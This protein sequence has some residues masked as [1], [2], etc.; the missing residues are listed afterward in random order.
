VPARAAWFLL[1]LFGVAAAI[2][3]HKVLAHDAKP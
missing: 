1:A 2:G 3:Y